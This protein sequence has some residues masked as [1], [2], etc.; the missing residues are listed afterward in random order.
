L[1]WLD[2]RARHAVV[3]LQ[4]QV[5]TLQLQF[6]RTMPVILN[7]ISSQL[8][9]DRNH[10][11]SFDELYRRTE[12]IRREI[13]FELRYATG[14]QPRAVP[15]HETRILNP[16]KLA[17]MGDHVRINLGAGHIPLDVYLNVDQRP[18]DGI[19]VVADVRDLPFEKGSLG[20]IF[21]THVLEHFPLEELRRVL[22]PYW[23]A[24]LKPGGRFVAVVPDME[25][26]ISECAAGRVPFED[27]REVAYGS[28]EYE[29]DFHFNGFSQDLL[30]SILSEA[31]L[32]DVHIRQAGRR[33]GL[34]Y[35]MEVEG[36]RL[37]DGAALEGQ[38]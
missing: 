20:E 33:N 29:G 37:A 21:S 1:A 14:E 10:A 34:C 8:A 2:R 3:P 9:S 24:L 17:E 5:D 11:R 12:F 35:E 13:M 32:S 31:G 25:T 27:F 7:Q 19:D 26:M 28:Q 30:T 23:T 38:T 4:L 22:L 36:R 16:A 18:L 6:D 15:E